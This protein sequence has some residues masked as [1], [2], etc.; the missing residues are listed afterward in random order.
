M[1]TAADIDRL[2][3]AREEVVAMTARALRRYHAPV[4]DEPL[5]M[6]LG[7]PGR[8]G[9]VFYDAAAEV[10]AKPAGRRPVPAGCAAHGGAGAAG[11]VRARGATPLSAPIAG[12]HGHDRHQPVRHLH[13][14]IQPAASTRSVALPGRRAASASRTRDLQGILEVIHDFDLILRELSG[15]DQFVFQAGGGADAAYTHCSSRAPITQ[16]AASWRSATRSSPRSRRIRATPRP[17]PPPA[18]RSSR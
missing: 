12:D 18:S 13:D 3:A 5:V 9:R 17:P 10:V 14:E 16:R 1:H 11:D 4:W 2:A 8:R 15:M 6:E 7:R